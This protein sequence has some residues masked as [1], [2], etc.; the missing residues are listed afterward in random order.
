M[1]CT[2]LFG[3]ESEDQT[4]LPMGSS[5]EISF[6]ERYHGNKAVARCFLNVSQVLLGSGRRD[7]R[8]WLGSTRTHARHHQL[9]RR[10]GDTSVKHW[11]DFL[12]NYT[13]SGLHVEHGDVSAMEQKQLQKSSLEGNGRKKFGD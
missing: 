4:G 2:S 9:L 6:P 8:W 1:T 12:K 5:K 10:L 11:R 7:V 3:R 13:V